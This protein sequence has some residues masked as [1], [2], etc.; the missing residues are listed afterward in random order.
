MG[1]WAWMAAVSLVTAASPRGVAPTPAGSAEE[2]VSVLDMGARGD[3]IADDT[4]AFAR[5][6]ATGKTVVVPRPPA[7]YRVTRTIR[8]HASIVGEGRPLVRMYGAAGRESHAMLEVRGY[9]GPGLLIRGLHLDGQWDGAGTAGEWSHNVMVK[10]SR[11][12]TIEDNVLERP[13]G[14]NVLIGGEG[15]PEPS[16]HVIVRRNRLLEPR[17][18]AVA[19]IS[20]RGVL[21]EEN[22]IRRRSTYV[23]AID[24]E[25]NPNGLDAVWDVAVTGN[26]LDVA[27]IAIQVFTFG[28]RSPPSGRVTVSGNVARA[29]RFFV[30]P[31]ETSAWEEL[32]LTG[33][34][35]LGRGGD[36]N[37]FVEVSPPVRSVRILENRIHAV[38][39]G[40]DRLVGIEGL[41][42]RDNEWTGPRG[43][44]VQVAG[45]P[46]ARFARNRITGFRAALPPDA[47]AGAR[48]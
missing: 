10:G 4:E 48:D 7:H 9:R 1:G 27:G 19:V 17:R 15:V 2:R 34:T 20:A 16:E 38:R 3:G 5:A 12:V 47:A 11:N 33:N 37:A 35:F 18:C 13:Y 28:D 29:A 8:L 45:C 40:G 22:V 24:L 43:Y 21:V 31:G 32:T 26:D 23:A 41:E 39:A 25:P 6:A 14:D 36:R 30:K 46:A 42:V 44:E